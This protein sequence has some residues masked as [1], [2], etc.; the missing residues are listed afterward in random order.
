MNKFNRLLTLFLLGY[1]VVPFALGQDKEQLPN[2]VIIMGDDLGW[3]DLSCYGAT[4]TYTPAIDSLAA[5]GM[6]FTD[7]H[8]SSSLCSPSRYSLMTGRYSWRTHLKK[9]VLKWFAKPLIE[10][11]RTTLGTMLQAQGYQTAYIGKWHLGFEWPLL[12]DRLPADA[13]REVFDTWERTSQ[14]YIDFSQ[15]V[16]QGPTQ[17][18]FDYYYGI[19]ASNNMIP[20]VFIEN[21]RVVQPPTVE[22]EYVYDTDQAK[23]RAPNWELEKLD[24]H[25]TEQAVKVIDHHFSSVT[26]NPLMLIFSTASIHRPCLPTFTKGKSKAGLRG[27]MVLE[28][29][30]VVNEVVQALKQHGAFE[31]TLLI[32]TSDNGAVPG[33]P[34]FALERYHRDLGDK[35]YLDYF[36]GQVPEHID[37][38][39]NEIAQKG[40]YTYGHAS[41]GPFRGFKSEPWEGGHRI[42]L[43]VHWPGRIRAGDVNDNMICNADVMATLAELTGYQGEIGQD[44]YSFLTNLLSQSPDQPRQSMVLA[45]GRS[46]ALITRMGEWKYIAEADGHQKGSLYNMVDDSKEQHNVYNQYPDTVMAIQQ[47]ID[48]VEQHNKR[49]TLP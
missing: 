12:A 24:Q 8:S 43:I 37:P 28:F 1:L 25:L 46:G 10:E 6:R 21:D 42:P 20:F 31:N 32:V 26:K 41:A 18:G 14:D 36:D 7:A 5:H 23:P 35:Y 16:K 2:I 49:E 40:W 47:L 38:S 29:D 33:D 4:G 22:K 13:D 17:R 11:G 34:V 30:W 19:A 45:S 39:G 27:D 44:S 48:Q 15:P 3:G 9:G